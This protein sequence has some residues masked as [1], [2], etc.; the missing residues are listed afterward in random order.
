MN[1]AWRLRGL[2]TKFLQTEA[3]RSKIPSNGKKKIFESSNAFV[4]FGIFHPP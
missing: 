3:R 4:A 1:L 2:R